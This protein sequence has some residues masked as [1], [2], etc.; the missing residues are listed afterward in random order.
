MVRYADD[1]VVLCRTAEDAEQALATVRRW[2]EAAG[3][4]LHPAK[5][6]LVDMQLPGGFDFLGYHF[7]RGHRW[8]R[9]K[10]LTKLK[11]AVRQKT[12]RANGHSLAVIICE[13]QPHAP[14]LVCVLQTQRRVVSCARHVGPLAS[15]EYSAEAIGSARPGARAGPSALADGVL[16]RAGALFFARCPCRGPPVR[17]AVTPQLESRMRE[18]RLSG[19][20]GGARETNCVSLP[21]SKLAK[22]ASPTSVAS[23]TKRQRHRVLCG[24]NGRAPTRR[25]KPPSP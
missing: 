1:F 9:Q 15:A 6:H 12:R 21:L 19:S 11:D 24:P 23:P 18:I 16:C 10:S 14:W 5:T 4:Q 22:R 7:E 13:C 8:P 3:L 20:E 2:T 17:S 25:R